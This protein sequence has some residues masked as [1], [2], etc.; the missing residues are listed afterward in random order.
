M[1]TVEIVHLRSSSE[2]VDALAERIKESIWMDGSDGDTI[3]VFRRNGLETDIAIHIRHRHSN[4]G[5]GAS[6]LAF[7][8]A[9][10]LRTFG[11]VE[12]TVWEEMP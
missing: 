1:N 3:T 7:N 5:N 10:A 12:H 6:T 9:S 4:G 11:I 2:P 8:L